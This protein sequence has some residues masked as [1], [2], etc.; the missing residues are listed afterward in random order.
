MA[1]CSRYENELDDL[2]ARVDQKI[3]C[4][5]NSGCWLWTGT[6]NQS[7]YAIIRSSRKWNRADKDLRVSRIIYR[8]YNGEIA[9][10]FL[11][12]HT[13]DT[14]L[15]VNPRH[16]I[17]GTDQDNAR[18]CAKRG[19]S[20]KRLNDRL[21]LEIV[22]AMEGGLSNRKTAVKFGINFN[23]AWK[24]SAGKINALRLAELRRD[25]QG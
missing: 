9:D 23:T 10:G 17:Q 22:E 3:S 19:R 5:P 7:G 24:I 4:E 25:Y 6:V 13:C 15:C 11:L 2:Y 18:D 8:R 21:L 16:L 1:R 12:R 14:P 20:Y